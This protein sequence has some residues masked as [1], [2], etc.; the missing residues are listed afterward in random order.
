MIYLI[1]AQAACQHLPQCIEW[2]NTVVFT[3]HCAFKPKAT[4]IWSDFPN[5]GPLPGSVFP[6]V[7]L[8]LMCA[9]RLLV[10]VYLYSGF[11]A[12]GTPRPSAPPSVCI[13][14]KSVSKSAS[15]TWLR[16]VAWEQI[17]CSCVYLVLTVH[18]GLFFHCPWAY[19]HTVSLLRGLYLQAPWLKM[20]SILHTWLET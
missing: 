15:G 2:D 18:T 17:S 10:Y 14:R 4:H 19:Q 7:Q 9:N 16:M 1:Q 20:W 6:R 5:G 8:H 13:W 3:C 11:P 12:A